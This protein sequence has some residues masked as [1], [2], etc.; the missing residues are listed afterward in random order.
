MSGVRVFRMGVAVAIA[1]FVGMPPAES[2]ADSLSLPSTGSVEISGRGFG[3]GMGMSQ[4]GAQG[5]ALQ[6]LTWSQI[7]AF[8]F[9]GTT[10]ASQGDPALRI[11]I[12]ADTDGA[13]EVVAAPGQTLRVGTDA[14]TPLP[15]SPTTTAWRVTRRGAGLTVSSWDQ[16]GA[17]WVE[18]TPPGYAAGAALPTPVVFDNPTTHR[19]RLTLPGGVRRDYPDAI[20]AAV[21]GS[22][23]STFNGTTFEPYLVSVVGS[24]MPTS[25]RADALRS[26][27]V[28]ARTYAAYEKA[29]P[30]WGSAYDV[31]DSTSCQVYRG[32]ADYR[33]DGSLISDYRN[34]AVS[35]ATTATAGMTVRYA[36]AAALTMFS[37]SNGGWT[38]AGSVPY[39]VAQPDPYDASTSGS[40]W[41]ISGSTGFRTKLESAYP[42]IGSLRN[43]VLTRDGHGEWGGR[44]LS[45]DL[46]G[47]SGTA[48]KVS[49]E[50]IRSLLGI[51]S[52]WFTLTDVDHLRRDLT[53]D[54]Q[55]DVLGVTPSGLLMR[56][57]GKAPA[58]GVG[59]GSG[60]S[61]GPG[62]QT[63]DMLQTAGDLDGNGRADILGRVRATGQRVCYPL[64]AV[65]TIG[66]RVPVRGDWSAFGELIG[67]G[68]LTSDGRADFISRRD[69]GRLML[70][71][72][73]GTCGG[74]T[75][76]VDLGP[77]WN[78]MDVIIGVGD[79]DRD[80]NA[81]IIARERATGT[82][83]LY[84]RDGVSR[85]T[86]RVDL[87]WGWNAMTQLVPVGDV[88]GL[89]GADVLARDSSGQAW[90]YPDLGGGVWKG[91]SAVPLPPSS[92]VGLN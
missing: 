58:A 54:G 10:L 50:R 48:S 47:T 44:V 32:I 53:G 87:G 20:G 66:T 77:G 1:L 78:A 8:Y 19:T 88:D 3:H 52:N 23:L 15:T 83:W 63:L 64:S 70:F 6:G 90:L 81:D 72:G 56:L 11:G 34:A 37:S 86:S 91:R 42:A 51:R 65:G 35:A 89:G 9:P 31:C 30:R 39:L 4:W 59:F 5:A 80:G 29:H 69:D 24:E 33:S 26:Q 74:W 55:P 45:A 75:T 7:I 16:T 21:N 18:Y 2:H 68:D 92:Y 76:S 71:Q 14:A 40:T 73:D 41:S 79:A 62:W 13:T 61:L 22:G 60:T 49:G 27:A 57:P 82:L 28:A 36:G 46:V 25:W 85:W 67:V 12:T 38:V 84:T 43:V 17:A